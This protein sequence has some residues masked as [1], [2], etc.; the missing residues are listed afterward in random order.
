MKLNLMMKVRENESNND[1]NVYV[2]FIFSSND[3]YLSLRRFVATSIKIGHS[4]FRNLLK[5]KY[6]C[7]LLAFFISNI[8]GNI[9]YVVSYQ[10]VN[11]GKASLLC[12]KRLKSI[13]QFPTF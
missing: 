9:F 7:I 8:A 2:D 3:I 13:A 1:G 12:K 6:F 11:F 4:I 5:T 10:E